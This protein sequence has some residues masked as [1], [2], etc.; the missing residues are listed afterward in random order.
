MKH[1]CKPQTVCSPSHTHVHTG[2]LSRRSRRLLQGEVIPWL[3][4]WLLR[5][6]HYDEPVSTYLT[7]MCRPREEEGRSDSRKNVH[8]T[9]SPSPLGESRHSRLGVLGSPGDAGTP[10]ESGLGAAGVALRSALLASPMHLPWLDNRHSL[11]DQA[12]GRGESGSL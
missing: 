9:R 4:L 7:Q 8:C 12:R 3:R 11:R 10:Q 1:E 6:L 2:L 5:S